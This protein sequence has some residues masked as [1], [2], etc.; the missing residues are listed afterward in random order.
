MDKRGLSGIITTVVL[1]ALSLVAITIVWVFIQNLVTES[2]EGLSLDAVNSRVDLE[3]VLVYSNGSVEATV[4]RTSGQANL[5]GLIFAISSETDSEVFEISDIQ[6]NALEKR[7][8]T[9]TLDNLN[10]EDVVSVSV[11]PV[12][13][14]DSGKEIPGEINDKYEVKN[15]EPIQGESNDDS[16]DEPSFDPLAMDGLVAYYA[17]DEISGEVV[18]S[19]GTNN[20]TN[21][22]ATRGVTGKIE[23]AFS[24][25]GT[26]DYVDLGLDV[27]PPRQGTLSTWVYVDEDE[28]YSGYIWITTNGQCATSY[29]YLVYKSDRLIGYYRDKNGN[30]ETISSSNINKGQWYYVTYAWGD[31]GQKIYLNGSLDVINSSHTGQGNLNFIQDN[32]L[33]GWGACAGQ[34]NERYFLNG[35]LDE[36]AI[37]DRQLT[38]QEVEDLYAYYND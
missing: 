16:S 15:S 25:D 6:L 1:I 18:D 31:E 37:W 26:N 32:N 23:N 8:W 20:G 9:L 5:T 38:D 33:G 29:D 2:T 34:D 3:R 19:Q 13:T 12:F 17:L 22:G 30:K 28:D 24:F 27:L 10:P 11:A 21:E 14:S 7:T 35:K 36:F 4:K